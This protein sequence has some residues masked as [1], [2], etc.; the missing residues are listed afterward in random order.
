MSDVRKSVIVNADQQLIEGLRL[1]GHDRSKSEGL[2]FTTYVYFIREGIYKHSLSKEEAFDAYSDSILSAMDDL[3]N[4]SFQGRS[5]LKTWL[6]QIFHNKCVDLLRKKSTNKNSV[7]NTASISDMMLELS[8]TS[9][10]VV[11]RLAEKADWDLLKQKLNELGDTCRR[12]LTLS[13]DGYS[14]KE[15]STLMDYKTADVV[16]TSR[17]RCLEKLRQLYKRP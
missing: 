2:L 12:L 9:K 6:Y 1:E 16:K 10:S 11:Q 14:D 3:R 17:L 4:G 8:D 7:H 5:T 15:I 13:A